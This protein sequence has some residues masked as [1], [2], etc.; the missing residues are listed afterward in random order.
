MMISLCADKGSPGVTTAALA[1]AMTWPEEALLA[2]LDPAGSDI[3]YRMPSATGEP[4]ALGTGAVSLGLAMRD[5]TAQVDVRVHQQY[6][7][8][9]TPVLV[10]PAS[11]EQSESIGTGWAGIGQALAA[12]N[13]PVI[14]DCGRLLS[15]RSPVASVLTASDMVVMVAR[16]TAESI[17]HLRRGLSM[18][19]R[20]L[21]ASN[22]GRL[23]AG[24][25]ARLGVLIVQEPLLPMSASR[26]RRE[27]TEVLA[28]TPG[29][30]TV[31]VFG[32]LPADAK[33]AAALRNLKGS[34][35]RKLPILSAAR[36][37]GQAISQHVA[38]TKSLQ[39]SWTGSQQQLGG[40][41]A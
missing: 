23:A 41:S 2:E 1:L 20:L 16:S 24:A 3:P 14:A 33:G 28:A 11:P 4:V 19:S 25:L 29:L 5:A 40:V 37:A 13:T 15:P 35:L 18:V 7:A 34:K 9:G 12:H 21:N 8:G 17:A 36:D 10:G 31:P 38:D 39:P 22:D 32:V 6:L 27:V 26:V 30:T